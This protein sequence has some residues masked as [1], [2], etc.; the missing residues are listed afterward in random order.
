S[1][2]YQAPVAKEKE[3]AK[4]GKGLPPL[5]GPIERRLT[6]EQFLDSLAQVTGYW[7]KPPTMRVN[8]PNPNV[9][10]W[11]HQKPDALVTAL[12]RPNREQVCTER[13]QD[14]SVL[15]ALELVNGNVMATRLREGVKV[16]LASPLGREEDMDKVART[17]YQ[18][19]LNRPPTAAELAL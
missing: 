17:L 5:L 10:A 8:V 12:G 1:R 6:S 7:P 14:S 3:K 15:Q 9:R 11:R 4:A 2:V 16:L 19:A 13:C 18:R